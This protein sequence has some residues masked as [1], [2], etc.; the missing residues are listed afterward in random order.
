MQSAQP[1][2]ESSF[3][4]ESRRTPSTGAATSYQLDGA[5]N[6]VQVTGG[7]D[8]GAYALSGAKPDPADGPMN[9]YTTTPSTT[10]QYDLNGNLI[11]VQDKVTGLPELTLT[12]DFRNMLVE[13][14]AHDTGTSVSYGYDALGRRVRKTVTTGGVT[15][16]VVFS[17]NGRNVIEEQELTTSK[18]LATYVLGPGIDEVVS[19]SRDTTGDSIPEEHYLHQDGLQSVVAVTDGSG[20]VIERLVYGDF[21]QTT[22]TDAAGAPM[23]QTAIGN[24]YGFAGR[25]YDAELDLYYLRTRYLDPSVGRFTSRDR[26][27]TWAD[28]I[29]MGNATAYVGHNPLRYI[30]PMGQTGV[31]CR[32]L[33]IIAIPFVMFGVGECTCCDKKGDL[34]TFLLGKGGTGA[35][36]PGGGLNLGPPPNDCSRKGVDWHMHIELGAGFG[37][38]TPSIDIDIGT[39]ADPLPEPDIDGEVNLG[40]P[41]PDA[42]AFVTAVKVIG[43]KRVKGG[44]MKPVECEDED[45]GWIADPM[46]AAR[47]A[48]EDGVP[49]AK[50]WL[51]DLEKMGYSQYEEEKR[52]RGIMRAGWLAE[53][54][55]R[56][57]KVSIRGLEPS[58]TPSPGVGR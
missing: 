4:R 52:T 19:M 39:T 45:D 55:K 31:G 37:P 30:D 3:A 48:V 35:G 9:Q 17:Y 56:R 10:R 13:A 16:E 25:R 18:T 50:E 42:S 53:L 34:V 44:C 38:I 1:V 12:Y 11:A 20:A 49:G 43:E 14:V 32:W 40:L 27:G 26:L 23:A 2:P 58:D 33:E 15:S 28:W 6:R 24:P 5:N 21:G 7:A 36:L 41:G 8:P 47:K 57:G 46:D 22:W 29:N 54:E 51:E